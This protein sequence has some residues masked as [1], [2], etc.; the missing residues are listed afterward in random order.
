[1]TRETAGACLLLILA[2]LGSLTAGCT[3]RPG[4]TTSD[5]VSPAE[6]QPAG[7]TSVALANNRFASELYDTLSRTG[8]GSRENIFFSPFSISSALAITY[9]GARGTTAEEIRAV[10]HFPENSTDRRTGYSRLFSGLGGTGRNSTLAVANALWAEKTYPFLPAYISLARDWYAANVTNLDFIGNPETSRTT[11]NGW[12]EEKTEDKIRDLLPEGTISMDT[13][14][15]IT[16]AIYFNG[17]WNR[18]FDRN[19]TRTADFTVAPGTTVPVQMMAQTDEKAVYRYAET[20]TF[21]V[22]ELPYA[23]DGGENLSMIFLLPKNGNLT[24]VG[25]SPDTREIQILLNATSPQRVN[26]YIPKFRLE[27][28][29]SLNGVLAGMGMPTAF[30]GAAD[31]SE[32]DGSPY[33]YISDVVHKAYIDVNEEGTEAAAATAVVLWGKGVVA[34]KPVPVFRADHPFLFFI[35]DKDTGTILFMGRVADPSG[36]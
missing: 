14:L 7:E 16:N 18:A 25:E 10:F 6:V 4:T 29:Y 31:F 22:L 30:S 24:S 33:L 27:T 13:R 23:G 3:D 34:E 17:T 11:I 19:A 28:E 21:Q 32:M 12:V 15:V 2:L 26:L 20:D 35:E 1:M 5:V 36:T 8:N 9:E